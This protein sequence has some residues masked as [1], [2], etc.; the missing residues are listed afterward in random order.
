MP[1]VSVVIPTFNSAGY[2]ERTI[3]AVQNQ[4]VVPNEII[5]VD[6]CS[7]DSTLKVVLQAFDRLEL[8]TAKAVR[9][10]SNSGP[11]VARNTGWNLATSEYVAFLDAD[12]SWHPKK[13]EIQLAI[14]ESTAWAS[15]SGHRY[16]VDETGF[17]PDFQLASTRTREVALGSF[18][19]RNLF[20]T[21]SVMIRRSVELR[22]SE[23][24]EMAED[25]LLWLELLTTGARAVLIDSPLVCL[26]KP[27]YGESGLSSQLRRM[28]RKDLRALAL[29]R[30]TDRL[31][32]FT[33]FAASVFSLLK[34]ARRVAIVRLRSGAHKVIR[35]GGT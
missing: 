29:L 12:D 27:A 2:I 11:G 22:F 9:L 26:H 23:D 4:T 21:P 7:S 14:M 15:F 33:Y 13:L 8:R 6:D 31:S 19:V 5:V 34:F 18:L 17:P 10:T 25:Y 24:R 32:W 16:L 35:T 1:S 20:C 30:R 3:N 28:E